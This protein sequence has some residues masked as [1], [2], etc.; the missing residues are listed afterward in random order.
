MDEFDFERTVNSIQAL[1][2][3]L[4][5]LLHS[6]SL[7][8]SERDREEGALEKDYEALRTLEANARA[9]VRGWK[10][11]GRRAH[12]LAP[13]VGRVN[14][15]PKGAAEAKLEVLKSGRRPA[16][17]I[18]KVGIMLKKRH[19]LLAPFFFLSSLSHE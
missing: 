19:P 15:V 9:E 3:T 17:G 1:E 6:V 11:R 13:G 2:A 16:A 4:N 14:D 7:L 8:K 5:P 10:E 12:A 18:F